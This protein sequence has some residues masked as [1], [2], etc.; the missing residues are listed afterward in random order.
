M[1]P[2]VIVVES[3]QHYTQGFI[4]EQS[5]RRLCKHLL[6]LLFQTTVQA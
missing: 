6:L 4:K 1:K 5:M 3:S 2:E